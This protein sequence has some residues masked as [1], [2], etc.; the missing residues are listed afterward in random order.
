MG[1]RRA[2]KNLNIDL[3]GFLDVITNCIGVLIVITVLA[4]I[5][6][7]YMTFV[8]RTPFVRK[9]EKQPVIL[10]C[11]KNRIVPVNKIEIQQKLEDYLEEIRKNSFDYD[12][13]A[14]STNSELKDVGD[15]YYRVDLAKLFRSNILALVPKA[16]TQGESSQVLKEEAAEFQKVLQGIDSEKEFAFLLVRP[17]SFEVFRAAR[18][19][20]WTHDVEI[21]WEPL[22]DGQLISF[23]SQGRRPTID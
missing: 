22:S 5:N 18:K 16:E 10:E 23:G 17:D 14:H 6:T 13:I 2:N 11:R 8:V 3:D 9:T 1:Y 19:L 21:G 20:L 7:K 15:K 4:M 12:R